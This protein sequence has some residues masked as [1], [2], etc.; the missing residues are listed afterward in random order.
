MGPQQVIAAAYDL[1]SGDSPR[2]SKG[3]LRLRANPLTY[4]HDRLQWFDVKVGRQSGNNVSIS[5]PGAQTA[6]TDALPPS[7]GNWAVEQNQASARF[8]GKLRYGSASMGVTIAS[9]KQSQDMIVRRFGDAQRALD[10][11][12]ARLSR[13]KKAVAA[14]R[15]ER[16]P[17]AGQILEVE[18]GWLPLYQ[19]LKAALSTVCEH[20]VPDRYVK[21]VGLSTWDETQVLPNKTTNWMGVSRATYCATVQISNPN[22]WLANRMGLIN[23]PGIV[24][25]L[26]PWSFVANMFGNFNQLVG[27]LTSEVGLNITDRNLTKSVK[28]LMHRREVSIPA[29]SFQIQPVTA[30]RMLYKRTDRTLNASPK[31]SFV[32]KVPEINWELCLIA[33]SLVVQR[34]DRINKLIRLL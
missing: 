27:S 28:M 15:K 18:F 10:R 13:D 7:W 1:S 21:G 20:G 16:E 2:D 33:G 12:L 8:N 32:A 22:L 29:S 17:L 24:W 5:P 25:D 6:R 23:L 31:L 19:D 9:W 26:V 14:L 3:K 4:R 34:I 11:S 30:S